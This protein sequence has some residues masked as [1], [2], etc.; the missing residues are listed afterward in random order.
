VLSLKVFLGKSSEQE[1]EGKDI[2]GIIFHLVHYGLN[3]LS[4]DGI[5][6]IPKVSSRLQIISETSKISEQNLKSL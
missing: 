6:R 1:E 3:P 5:H 4:T 2:I